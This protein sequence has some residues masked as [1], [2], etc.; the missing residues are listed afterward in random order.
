MNEWGFFALYFFIKI[1]KEMVII[2]HKKEDAR[3]F[4]FPQFFFYLERFQIKININPI[5]CLTH[6]CHKAVIHRLQSNNSKIIASNIQHFAFKF[7]QSKMR[8]VYKPQA[9]DCS[10]EDNH[11]LL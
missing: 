6:L 8:H 10:I 2:A 7:H 5:E 9:K 1:Y 11:H 3:I 4:F